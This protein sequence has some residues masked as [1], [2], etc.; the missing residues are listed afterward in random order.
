MRTAIVGAGAIGGLFGGL[1]AENNE[2]VILVDNHEE[3]ADR[4]N[5]DGLKIKSVGGDRIIKVRATNDPYE[6]GSVDLVIMA[7][8]SYDTKQAVKEILPMLSHD[9]SILTI[10]NG[11]GNV[12][13]ISEVAGFE[14]VV[15]GLTMQASTLIGLGEVF[16]AGKGA[17]IIG[18]L[19]S[20]MS[21]RLKRIDNMLNRSDIEAR[22]SNNIIGA[23]W[24]KVI[25]NVGINALTALTRMKNG[26]LLQSA[27][28]K[29][30]MK[31]AVMEAVDVSKAA[32]IR[33]GS[34]NPLKMTID[35]ASSTAMNRSSMLQDVDRGKRTEIDSLNGAIVKLGKEY[36][37]E[38]PINET[39]C[40]LVKRLEIA[41]A[42]GDIVECSSI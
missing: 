34:E 10:Q 23:M 4:V 7:V 9:T 22:I 16:H 33:I 42:R 27:E 30:V 19:D 29:E 28:V 26:G 14:H 35:V 13:A 11:L 2:D 17:T 36:G 25:V 1:L 3:R 31:R 39:L 18:E 8:K 32:K 38:T 21:L 12:E 41:L 24:D 5:H 20:R 15:G 37:I 6:V 40:A